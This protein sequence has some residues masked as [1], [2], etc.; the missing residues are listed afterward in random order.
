MSIELSRE[1]QALHVEDISPYLSVLLAI[2]NG[3]DL[4][5]FESI[6]KK[7]VLVS[8]KLE[9]ND[10]F[11][12]ATPAHPPF[13]TGISAFTFKVVKNP[14]WLDKKTLQVDIKN[15]EFHCVVVFSFG[16]YYG[17]YCSNRDLKDLLRQ[18]ILEIDEA[19]TP[20]P[21]PINKLFACF[22][23]DDDI[24]MLWLSHTG[25]RNR[26]K[27]G[28]KFIGG[29]S[30]ADSLDPMDDQS[31]SMS[32]V[33]TQYTLGE[34]NSKAIGLNP[35]KSLVWAGPSNSWERFSNRVIEI[36]DELNRCTDE[37]D[38]PIG[39]LSYPINSL[40]GVGKAYELDI[41]NS[42]MFAQDD[43]ST[44]AKLIRTIEQNY[45]YELDI[46]N[47]SNSAYLRIFHCGTP[48]GSVS[49]DFDLRQYRVVFKQ[50][51]SYLDKKKGKLDYFCRIFS[52]P[53]LVKV[54][55][56]SAHSMLNGMVFKTEL[57]DLPFDS[58]IWTDFG[59]AKARLKSSNSLIYNEKP[60]KTNDSGKEVYDP[61]Q[62]GLANSL[63]CWVKKNWN[64][65]WKKQTDFTMVMN[66]NPSGWL[67]CDDGSGEK[68]DFIHI[69]EHHDKKVVTFIHIKSAKKS[70]KGEA[71]NG[72]GV[73]VG[74]HDVVVNQAVKNIRYC[75]RKNLEEAIKRQIDESKVRKVWK[76]GNDVEDGMEQFLK[77]VK[78]LPISHDKRVVVIQPHTLKN[79]YNTDQGSKS[80]LQLNTLLLS[81][82]RAC[83]SNGAEFYMVGTELND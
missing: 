38:A 57:K 56:E 50:I 59:E 82:R 40:E 15:T 77:Q 48:C 17:I 20:T 66:E 62:I 42:E 70:P 37:N 39:I 10:I 28:S 5:Q 32:A 13:G 27:P 9:D 24:R 52:Y 23:N 81:A 47:F 22:I 78:S 65:S 64:S 46:S 80:K 29:D 71:N 43:D 30:L 74:A 34:D 73:S 41:L 61:S 12:I 6:I 72:R 8:F 83:A 58:F 31:Y 2:K 67:Y 18:E 63:F 3:S 69:G 36:L 16:D 35:Y 44:V 54:W 68:A 51:P 25:G 14:S 76:D 49:L 55:F 53:D 4:K 7:R 11:D 33:R 79:V 1:L 21:V 60:T 75:D 45:S 19:N 26:Y